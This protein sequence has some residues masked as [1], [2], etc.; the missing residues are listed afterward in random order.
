MRPSDEQLTE[1]LMLDQSALPFL[2]INALQ[3]HEEY[4]LHHL[5]FATSLVVACLV[6]EE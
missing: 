6:G 4:F 2:C 3:V 5:L 1:I